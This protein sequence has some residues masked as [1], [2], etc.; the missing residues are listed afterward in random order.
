MEFLFCVESLQIIFDGLNRGMSNLCDT[1][2]L[3]TS[4]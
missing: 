2:L 3:M 1:V 4:S